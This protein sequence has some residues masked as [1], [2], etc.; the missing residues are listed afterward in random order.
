MSVDEEKWR[1]GV[2]EVC[3]QDVGLGLPKQQK[4]WGE[5]TTTVLSHGSAEY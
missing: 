2:C 3:R 5:N 4:K 1:Q